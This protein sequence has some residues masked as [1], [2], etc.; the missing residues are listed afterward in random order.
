M[1]FGVTDSGFSKKD[2]ATIRAEIDQELRDLISPN[3]NLMDTSVLGQINGIYSDKLRELWDVAEAVY[4]AMYPDSASKD[5][6]DQVASITGTYRLAAQTSKV[7]LDSLW[8]EDGVTI[9]AGSIIRVGEQGNSFKTLGAVSNASGYIAKVSVEAESLEYGPIQALAQSIDTIATPVV[10]WTAK[11]ATITTTAEPWNVSGD[12]Y[13]RIRMDEDGLVHRVAF[14]EGDF[15]DWTAAT[16]AELALVLTGSGRTAS[17]VNGFLRIESDTDGAGSY[18]EILTSDGATALDLT[19]GLYKGF[20]TTD[21]VL[22]RLTEEDPDFRVRRI[23]LLTGTGAATVDAIRAALLRVENVIQAFVFE[24][25]SLETSPEG[26]PGKSFMALV[27][28]GDSTEIAEAI[29]DV[30]PAGIETYGGASPVSVTVD[31]SQGV[32]HV[33]KFARPTAI[34]IYFNLTVRI[35]AAMFP[36]DGEDQIKEALVA[37]GDALQIGADVFAIQF[38]CVPLSVAG[39]IDINSFGIGIDPD[40][41][42]DANIEIDYDELATFD[43]SDII[44]VTTTEAGR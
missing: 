36:A 2:L 11:A 6:L 14:E 8:I 43:S 12:I 17:E 33:V 27:Q 40:A 5:A 1:T 41:L 28:G 3:L 23:E 19:L 10:G 25:T 9:P 20:N 4:R 34:P 31:D 26:L 42:A 16:A 30:K 7:L 18:V 29:W 22:G 21:A 32:S 13:L 15:V 24:N 39:V 38:K 35:D 37:Y 44:L